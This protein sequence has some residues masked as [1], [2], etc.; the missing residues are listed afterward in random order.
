[1]VD[2]AAGKLCRE[3]ALNS[4]W[5]AELFSHHPPLHPTLSMSQEKTERDT[6]TEAEL[7]GMMEG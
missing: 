7:E 5:P 2:S 6:E 3:A 1:M 4:D